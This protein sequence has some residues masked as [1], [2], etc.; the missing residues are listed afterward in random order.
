MPSENRHK[1]WLLFIRKALDVP[2]GYSKEELLAF[3][4]I[5]VR[6]HPSLAPIIEDYLRLAE[7]SE[8]N[9]ELSKARRPNQKVGAAQMHL[10]DLLREK[11]FFPQNLDL[12]SSPLGCCHTCARSVSIRCLVATLPLA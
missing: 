2:I 6:E 9:S 11:K 12:L 3:R 10:F 5:A 1:P 7:N 4:S 8:I